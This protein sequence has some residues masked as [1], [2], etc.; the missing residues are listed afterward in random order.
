MRSSLLLRASA[1][2]AFAALAACDAPTNAAPEKQSGDLA[3]QVEALGFRGDMV[4][5]FGEYVLVEGDIVIPKTHLRSLPPT[6]S[7]DPLRPRFQYRTNA[8]VGSPKVHQITVDVSGLAGVPDWQTAALDA[9]AQWNAVP[10]SYVRMVQGS[11]ADVTL[12]TNCGLGSNVA[13]AASWPSGGNPGTTINVN[14]C[15]V[16]ALNAQQRLHNMVHE[17]GHT[18]GFRHSNY[19][20]LGETAGTEGAVHVFNTPTSGGDAGSAM[21]GGTALNAWAGFSVNDLWATRVLYPLPQASVTVTN[22]AGSPLV[23]WGALVGAT[24][25]AADLVRSVRTNNRGDGIIDEEYPVGTTTG[26]SLLDPNWSY[27]GQSSSTTT[28]GTTTYFL[29]CRY[30]VTTTFANGASTVSVPAPVC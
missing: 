5:D 30:R 18:L 25:Y 10:N 20:Q 7:E 11:P 12:G 1:V 13:A 29:T 9:M 6:P 23:S 2:L 4:R 28:I 24:S 27:T 21:N 19:T 22:S 15:F 14:P 8:L 16:F 17:F 26:T 3:R